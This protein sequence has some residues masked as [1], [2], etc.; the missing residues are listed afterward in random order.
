MT[1]LNASVAPWETEWQLGVPFP[2]TR[3]SVNEC[4]WHVPWLVSV[5][6]LD[7]CS[8]AL[9]PDTPASV[10]LLTP[11]AYDAP[12]LR[13]SF[14]DPGAATCFVAATPEGTLWL[15]CGEH[16]VALAPGTPIQGGWATLSW[17]V[18]DGRLHV[19]NASV[20]VP[21][22]SLAVVRR[23]ELGPSPALL[24]HAIGELSGPDVVAYARRPRRAESCGPLV[25][26]HDPVRSQAVSSQ[27]VRYFFDGNDTVH[28]TFRLE[29][30]AESRCGVEN[31]QVPLVA[32][33]S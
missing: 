14:E 10:Q 15:Q 2:Y 29:H 22:E 9:P 13:V 33:I 5:P 25:P 26:V 24:L 3:I 27:G 30:M 18:E 19:A 6:R 21:G 17:R 28:A 23:A 31:A 7:N 1:V 16:D 4:E 8:M 32:S 11:G 20:P 12:I